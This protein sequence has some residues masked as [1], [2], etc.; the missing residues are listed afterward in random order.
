MP[1]AMLIKAYNSQ[2]PLPK[3]QTRSPHQT[4]TRAISPLRKHD[5]PAEFSRLSSEPAVA[6]TLWPQP[7]KASTA[8]SWYWQTHH[9]NLSFQVLD[10]PTT[11][12]SEGVAQ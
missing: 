7:E 5:E 2:R 10:S 4:Q 3:S 9:S 12:S 8:N 11:S 1:Q 6:T